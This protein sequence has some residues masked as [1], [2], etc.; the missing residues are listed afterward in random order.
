[1]LSPVEAQNILN[2]HQ[3]LRSHSCFQSAVEMVLKLYGA[4]RE[5]EYPEQNIP[6]NDRR[7]FEPFAGK[8]KRY[9]AW[10]VIF[11]ER[12]FEPFTPTALDQGRA[13]LEE[14][15]YPIYSFIWPDGSGYHG[16]VGF[17]NEVGDLCFFTKKRVGGCPVERVNLLEIILSQTKTE[18]LVVRASQRP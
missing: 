2:G 14:G 12:K 13:L 1:M 4:L 6:A 15:V 11:E 18:L 5:G 7:G 8:T 16:F 9:G 17:T 3:Q 10:E